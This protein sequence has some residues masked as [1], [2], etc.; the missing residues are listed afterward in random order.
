[1]DYFR[2]DELGLPDVAIAPFREDRPATPA[3]AWFLVPDDEWSFGL[4]ILAVSPEGR[5]VAIYPCFLSDE[6]KSK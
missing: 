4:S 6:E 2:R 5:L 1:M 3:G